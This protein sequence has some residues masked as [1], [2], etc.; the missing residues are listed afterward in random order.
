MTRNLGEGPITGNNAKAEFA[1][2]DYKSMMQ[3]QH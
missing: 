2:T 1:V 3:R